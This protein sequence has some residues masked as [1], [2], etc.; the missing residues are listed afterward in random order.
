MIIWLN[1]AFG[2]GKTTT[3]FELI[4]KRLRLRLGRGD[5]WAKGQLE[6]C[7]YAFDSEITEEEIVTDDKSVQEVVEAVAARAGLTLLADNRPRWRKSIDR[8]VTLLKHIRV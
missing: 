5:A 8:A 3:A 2:V 7:L 6:R 1:G 4:L